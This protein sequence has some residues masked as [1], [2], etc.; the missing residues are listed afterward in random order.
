MEGEKKRGIQHL[1]NSAALLHE[2]EIMQNPL[3]HHGVQFDAFP[4]RWEQLSNYQ[5]C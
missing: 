3:E 4:V 2:P 1:D 5:Y